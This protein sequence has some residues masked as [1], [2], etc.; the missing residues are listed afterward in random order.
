MS[1]EVFPEHSEP[2][3]L[4]LILLRRPRLLLGQLGAFAQIV[5]AGADVLNAMREEDEDLGQIICEMQEAK[6]RGA[7]F[8]SR[9]LSE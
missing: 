8:D 3:A 9:R 4:F 6:G 7:P 2:L 1:R 5:Q